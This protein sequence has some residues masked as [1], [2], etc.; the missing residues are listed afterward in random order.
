MISFLTVYSYSYYSHPKKTESYNSIYSIFIGNLLLGLFK[1]STIHFIKSCTGRSLALQFVFS[2]KVHLRT[3]NILNIFLSSRLAFHFDGRLFSIERFL[4]ETRVHETFSA[5]Y[6]GFL[7]QVCFLS[8]FTLNCW[9]TVPV[10]N[11][12][13]YQISLLSLFLNFP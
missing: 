1:Q 5:F 2:S 11:P 12:Q 4:R 13:N 9:G 10:K 3:P 8:L 6:Y 7:L